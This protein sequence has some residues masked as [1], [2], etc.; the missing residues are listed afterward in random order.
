MSVGRG[1]VTVAPH[2][3]N[4]VRKDASGGFPDAVRFG[5]G[6][7]AVI[8]GPDDSVATFTNIANGETIPVAFKRI[9]ATGSSGIADIIGIYI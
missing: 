6:G 5:T 3:S 7:T 2:D 1:F 9:N 8:V 4:D